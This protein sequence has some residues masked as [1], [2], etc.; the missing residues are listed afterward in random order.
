MRHTTEARGGSMELSMPMNHTNDATRRPVL[1]AA[2]EVAAMAVEE[3]EAGGGGGDG[4]GDDVR[5]DSGGGD[6][7]GGDWRWW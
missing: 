7:S 4:A 2:G 6:G 5:G 3:R 1:K